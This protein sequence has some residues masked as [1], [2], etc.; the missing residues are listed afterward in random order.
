MLVFWSLVSL[1]RNS[2]VLTV[3][4]LFSVAC[5]FTVHEHSF[6]GD[7]KHNKS[8]RWDIPADSK[9]YPVVDPV[10][11]VVVSTCFLEY[12]ANA[13]IDGLFGERVVEAFKIKDGALCH[14]LTFFPALE[15]KTGWEKD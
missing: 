11:G 2:V 12:G 5:F 6:R 14:L 15:G 7:F 9:L 10:R 13:P 8:F 1:V 4:L 3:Y